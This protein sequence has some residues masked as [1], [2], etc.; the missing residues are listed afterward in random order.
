MGEEEKKEETSE[1]PEIPLA[2]RVAALEAALAALA[3]GDIHHEI[4]AEIGRRK[5]CR[6][7]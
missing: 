4:F 6:K 3:L 7:R 2:D 5:P 1:S